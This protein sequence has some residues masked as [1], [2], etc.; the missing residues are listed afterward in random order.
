LDRKQRT[1]HGGNA[2]SAGMFEFLGEMLIQLI[3]EFLAWF[4]FDR[5]R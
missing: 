1:E 4:F 5:R 3:I 2:A